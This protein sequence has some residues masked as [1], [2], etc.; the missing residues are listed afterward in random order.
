MSKKVLIT[1][2]SRGIGCSVAKLAKQNGY[3][4]ILHGKTVSNS[5]LNLSKSL[6][7]EYVN[8]D[9]RN[10]NETLKALD[11]IK[12]LDAV[13][14]SAGV[15]I[16]KPF[17]DLGNDDWRYIYEINVFGAT[18]VIKGTKKLLDKSINDPCIVNL[19]SVK[20]FPHSVGRVAYSSSKAA[21]NSITSGLAKEFAP[22]IRVNA[23]APG[24]T[25]TEMTKDTW[26]DRIKKQVDQILL[27]RIASKEEIALPILFLLGKE[28]S[29]ITGQTLLVDGG[30]SIKSE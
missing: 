27:K 21:I 12:N 6:K 5:L 13:I 11:Q 1:G 28:S 20:S 16:S 15:N 8:F 29:Y 14:N 22:K 7:C 23:I 3:E 18:N 9:L 17:C 26:S 2:S 25:D 24:F 30:F 4:I 19:S 10:I